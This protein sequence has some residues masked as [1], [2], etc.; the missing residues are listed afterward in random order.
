[1]VI[2]KE[3]P[4]NG[5]F[6]YMHQWKFLWDYSII[7]PL[8][9]YY[10]IHWD[11][12]SF[13]VCLLSAN[14]IFVSTLLLYLVITTV[15]SL[16]GLF[17]LVSAFQQTLNRFGHLDG[18][19]FQELLSGSNITIRRGHDQLRSLKQQID[20][21]GDLWWGTVCVKKMSLG[22]RH[23]CRLLRKYVWIRCDDSGA[24]TAIPAI[25]TGSCA[26][27]S[28]AYLIAALEVLRKYT[29]IWRVFTC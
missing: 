15:I 23:V 20:K 2:P 3:F 9:M 17:S 27:A 13:P 6:S 26:L 24:S 5:N 10:I 12:C 14:Y 21:R 8:G 25:M 29:S 11:T 22:L 4:L 18:Q 7:H 19:C 16:V 28:I 1:M